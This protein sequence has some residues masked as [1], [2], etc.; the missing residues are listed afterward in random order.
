MSINLYTVT[1]IH[2]APILHYGIFGAP[3][4]DAYDHHHLLGP[5]EVCQE[6]LKAC[7]GIMPLIRNA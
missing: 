1:I 2:A 3:L 6:C 5:G 4:A 7:P